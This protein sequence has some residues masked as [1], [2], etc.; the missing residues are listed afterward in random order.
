MGKQTPHGSL[1]NRAIRI[2]SRLLWRRVCE[3]E[4]QLQRRVSAG[5][6]LELSL[7]VRPASLRGSVVEPKENQHQLLIPS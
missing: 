3:A 7:E 2:V 4:I 5:V 6:S 1:A